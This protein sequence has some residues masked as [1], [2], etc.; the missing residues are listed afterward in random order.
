[1]GH[2]LNKDFPLNLHQNPIVLS[3]FRGENKAP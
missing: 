1:M 3:H 2:A